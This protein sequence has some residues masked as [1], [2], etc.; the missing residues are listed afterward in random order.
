M[1]KPFLL[2][3]CLLFGAL[4]SLHAN[5]TGKITGIVKDGN[6]GE[7]LPGA[8]IIIEGTVLGASADVD[9]YFVILNVPP[10]T[11]NVRANMIGYTDVVVTETRVNI[12]Q[13]TEINF[14][15]EV[16][17]LVSGS[18]V[19]VIAERKVVQPDVSAS[20]ANIESA[21]IEALPVQSVN[22]VIGL[23]AGALGLSIRGGASN[24]LAFQVDG[25]T[26]RDER[27]NEPITGVSL[28]AVEEVQIQTGGFNAEY[29]NIQAGLINVITKEGSPNRY[30]GTITFRNS[31]PG[32]KH[33]GPSFNDPNSYWVRPY[34]DPEVA[35]VGTENG[36]WDENLQ[37][38]YPAFD[39]WNT[40]AALSL[41]D[42]DPSNDLTPE[43]AQRLF[44][45]QHRRQLDITESD[46]VIDA[47]VG[48]PVLKGQLGNLRFFASYR[49]EREMYM[50]PLSRDSYR[51][52]N[53]LLKLTSDITSSMKLSI[54]GYLNQVE[55]VSSNDVGA[56]G[57]F[58]SAEGIA[59]TLTNAGF[60]TNSRIFYDSY[61]ALTDVEWR[62]LSAKLNNTV[63]SKTFYEVKLEHTQVDY[64]TRPNRERNNDRIYEI[65]PGYFT[66][67]APF[68][69]EEELVNGIDGMLMGV[70]AN[71]FDTSIFKTTTFRFD[72]TSQL[73]R[74]NLF[75]TGFEVVYSKHD[76]SYGAVNT[77]L[78]TG[79]PFTEYNRSPLRGAV[80]MQDKLEFKG[81]IANLGLRLDYLSPG[82]KWFNVDPYDQGFYSSDFATGTEGEFEQVDTDKQVFLS[83]RLAVSHPI[84]EYAKLFFNYGHFR[85]M[86]EAENLY[87]VTRVT[88]NRVS[89]I[90]DPNLPLQKT[91]AYEL[92][93][94]H[95]L[96]DRYLMR[97]SGY[98][99][100]IS[101][102]PSTT[103]YQN[104][105]GKVTYSLATSNFYQDIRGLEFTLEKRGG[106]WFSGFFNYTYH[107]SSSGF[108]GIRQIFENPTDQREYLRD[109]P[110]TQSKPVARPFWRANINFYTPRDFGPEFA[111][112]HVLENW[113]LGLLGVWRSG[114]YF[115]W[116]NNTFISG[117]QN[118]MQWQD[119]KGFDLKLSRKFDF[120]PMQVEFFID[121]FNLFN[122]KNWA[123]SGSLPTG[124]VDGTDFTSYMR[125]LRLPEGVTNEFGY[126]PANGY[127]DDK[128][129]DYR[130][131]DVP[132]D[133]LELNPENDPAIARRNEERI[134]KKSYI[135]NPGMT[136][137]QFLNP[138]DV[139]VGV[140]L[141]FNF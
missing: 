93:Y 119:Y 41:Q 67:E 22:E 47:G 36:G 123:F 107:V 53:Y 8:N 25:I 105:N 55:S 134:S 111:G 71:A 68:G 45:W 131:S 38:Q 109:N 20:T 57:Y 106:D 95:S 88:G 100:D 65:V 118:N 124:F 80:Y 126:I 130:P 10:G 9:G 74:I 21:Q 63:S 58:R 46:Y 104:A 30:S 49:G 90:S 2:V 110:P 1:K 75:K 4:F 27:N 86:P 44:L 6:T 62:S 5:T 128:P 112:F 141:N 70:R 23:Q 133:P 61:W 139:Y 102:K 81:L 129:G 12:N 114:V 73:D 91:V 121:A 42:D 52:N 60:T 125:S 7:A 35:F 54:S 103:R 69:N 82:G 92:G 117:L 15:L 99:R 31:A 140:K 138:R 97:V 96:F 64:N 83:P 59:N 26:L 108:F 24:E 50:L 16:S 85:Q 79:R 76:V 11:Y 135:D 77:V 33:F 66:D 94:E 29:G 28:S 101:D 113:Q 116:T 48:G 87:E 39:G 32:A 89:F 51:Q 43:A 132:F 78:P 13:T 17:V 37:S 115:T 120:K 40:I 122:F 56:P 137:L 14:N 19:T 18:E 84:T 136:Y 3:L 98:Y 34:V 72:L 127:G